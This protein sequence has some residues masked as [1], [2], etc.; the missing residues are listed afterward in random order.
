[1]NKIQC[2]SMKKIKYDSKHLILITDKCFS[3]GIESSKFGGSH[4]P[5]KLN[6][7]SISVINDIVKHI[8]NIEKIK[9]ESPIKYTD[10]LYL[11]VK[12][13]TNFY[14]YETKKRIIDPHV[15]YEKKWCDCKVALHFKEIFKMNE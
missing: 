9:I 1:M 7:E 4:L 6:E 14:D 15:V 13:Y 2:E 8:E 12:D 11:K 5:I 10:M 3:Y